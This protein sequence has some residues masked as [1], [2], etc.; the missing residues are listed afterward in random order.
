MATYTEA[1]MREAIE[2][3]IVAATTQNSVQLAVVFPWWVLGDNE[4][5]WPGKLVSP[6]DG[7]RVHGYVIT[8]YQTVAE[9][10]NPGCVRRF[11]AYQIRGMR[12]Y[13]T[14]NRTANSDLIYNAELDAICARFAN[15]NTL[16]KAINRI[17]ADG[18][19][20]FSLDL[21]IFGGQLLHRSVGQI[22][23]EQI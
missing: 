17:T 14:G 23:I 3:E 2:G 6:G 10:V 19:L 21:K 5:Q 9:R 7:N 11:F 8:R 12:F 20:R 16:P 18:E 22:T 15:K 1:E 13:E 4:D